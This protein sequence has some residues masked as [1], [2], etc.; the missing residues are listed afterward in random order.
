[1]FYYFFMEETV[2]SRLCS[3]LTYK[4]ISKTAFCRVIGV[5]SSFVTSMRCSLKP[6]KLEKIAV[7]FPDLNRDW[8]LTGMGNMLLDTS[9]D[10]EVCNRSPFLSRL[11]L[12]IKNQGLNKNRF[13]LDCGISRGYLSN[14]KGEVGASV[15]LK[16]F[17]AY[18]SLN[19][20][21]MPRSSSLYSSLAALY[22]I[23]RYDR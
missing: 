18:P 4:H 19:K 16:I 3:Y 23:R 5:S 15:L 12:F 13:E 6:D 17:N 20:D 14:V 8:L 22:T 2:K 11:L 1:M 21:C 7:S 10:I 9:H